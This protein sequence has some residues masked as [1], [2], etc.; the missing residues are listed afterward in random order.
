MSLEPLTKFSISKG[1]YQQAADQNASGRNWIDQ[2]PIRAMK[3]VTHHWQPSWL[4]MKIN[5][6]QWPLPLGAPP[7]SHCVKP[8]DSVG[9]Q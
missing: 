1:C 5:G 4:F 7:Y 8:A 3:C 9:H 2:Q 6:R